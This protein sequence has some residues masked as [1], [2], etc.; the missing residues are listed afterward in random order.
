MTG[1]SFIVYTVLCLIG[2]IGSFQRIKSQIKYHV[3]NLT[4]CLSDLNE[5]SLGFAFETIK[6]QRKQDNF[7]K[8]LVYFL[9]IFGFVV[10]IAF[11]KSILG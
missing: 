6:N 3:K 2:T 5:N 1:E 8:M 7:I 9:L 10:L 4:V 11:M